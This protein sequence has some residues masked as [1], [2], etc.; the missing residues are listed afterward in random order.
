MES[1]SAWIAKQE[2]AHLPISKKN[3]FTLSKEI[4]VEKAKKAFAV[5]API[6]ELKSI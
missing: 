5:T 6:D 1:N 2:V 4:I 3:P